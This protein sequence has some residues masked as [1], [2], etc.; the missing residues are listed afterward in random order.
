LFVAINCAAIPES[1]LE[2]IL[3]GH[4]K[5]AF[6]GATTA[7]SGLLVKVD[8]GTLF[9]DE[10]GEMPLELQ[11][12]LVRA[13][14]EGQVRSVGSTTTVQVICASYQQPTAIFGAWSKTGSSVRIFC[15]DSKAPNVQQVR[16]SLGTHEQGLIISTSD[17]SKGAKAEAARV[18][19]VPVALMNGE[20]FV[21]LL[22]ANG[23]GVSKRS[24]ELIELGEDSDVE[25]KGE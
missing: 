8:K 14:D 5:G 12:K 10:I 21:A 6:S 15:I 23:I 1:L 11:A 18:D 24:H 3:F 17:F 19:A 7:R 22:V 13:L 2:S 9:L 25:G 16:G 4:V 20:Q